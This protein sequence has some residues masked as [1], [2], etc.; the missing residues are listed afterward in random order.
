VGGDRR[1]TRKGKTEIGL[2]RSGM[3]YHMSENKERLK[4][5]GAVLGK[6]QML[7]QNDKWGGGRTKT[8]SFRGK[9]LSL[10]LAK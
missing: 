2:E 10:F 6:D 3:V 5:S 7:G 9:K 1:W 4:K 8:Q